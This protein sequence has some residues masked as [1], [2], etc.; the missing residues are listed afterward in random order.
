VDATEPSRRERESPASDSAARDIDENGEPELA[1]EAARHLLAA[2]DRKG[3]AG[4]LVRAATHALSLGALPKAEGLL[5]E[6][7]QL[8]PSDAGLS[9]ELAGVAAH[10]RLTV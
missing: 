3:A 1:G 7:S 9:L 4:L 2:G 5:S 10:R 8:Q 6:A